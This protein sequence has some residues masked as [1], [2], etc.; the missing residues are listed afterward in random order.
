MRWTV[1]KVGELERDTQMFCPARIKLLP[2]FSQGQSKL[3][4]RE[5]VRSFLVS[6]E[7]VIAGTRIIAHM[8]PSGK[9]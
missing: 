2:F 8:A 6:G 1:E 3:L 5:D 7:D 4:S 9:E